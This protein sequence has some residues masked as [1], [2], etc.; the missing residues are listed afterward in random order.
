MSPPESPLS[1]PLAWN[2]VSVG[3]A[4]E[5]FDMFAAYSADALSLAQV[6]AG[7]RIVDVAAGPGSLAVQASAVARE[8]HAVDFAADMLA[9]LAAR[10][11]EGGITNVTARQE[12]GRAH[13]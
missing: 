1:T 3:Y 7:E 11:D 5:S 9:Q 6:T 8:V 2:L 13:V 12:I 4:A 10:I